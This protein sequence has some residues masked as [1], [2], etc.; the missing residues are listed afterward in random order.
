VKNLSLYDS[1][2]CRTS[3]SLKHNNISTNQVKHIHMHYILCCCRGCKTISKQQVMC[4][5]FQTATTQT[6]SDAK[7]IQTFASPSATA[8]LAY[9][10][11][12]NSISLIQYLC[13]CLNLHGLLVLNHYTDNTSSAITRSHSLQMYPVSDEFTRCP[14][15]QF[16]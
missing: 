14:R 5:L 3:L 4:I 16:Q 1:E 13:S 15:P 10:A 12:T 6:N 9:I 8:D 11:T 7:V 2:D